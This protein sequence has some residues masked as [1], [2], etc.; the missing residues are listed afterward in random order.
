MKPRKKEDLTVEEIREIILRH[1][2][3]MS[4]VAFALGIRPNGVS[5]TLAGKATSARIID[6]CRA[7]ALELLSMERRKGAVA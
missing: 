1:E 5:M 4:Q 7:K 3:S 6:A 2:G